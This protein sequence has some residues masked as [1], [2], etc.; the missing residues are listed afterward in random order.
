SSF[1]Y[2]YNTGVING[3][4]LII[5]DFLKYTV[6]ERLEDHPS[7]VCGH[8]FGGMIASCSVGLFV[9]RLGNS[10]FMVNLLALVRDCLMG[11]AK[12]AAAVEMLVLGHLI[13]SIFCGLC[14]GFVPMYTGEVSPSPLWDAFVIL[15][16]LG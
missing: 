16:H 1:Q 3:P 6:K 5:K 10:M 9:N 8:L 7:L 13:T 4:G 15:N 2:F 14:T 11:F 12:R